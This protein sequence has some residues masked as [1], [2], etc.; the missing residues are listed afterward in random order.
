MNYVF[1]SGKKEQDRYLKVFASAIGAKTVY[2]RHY[3]GIVPARN[4]N[5]PSVKKK[6]VLPGT[7]GIIFCGLLRGNAHI[8]DLALQ[9]NIPYYYVDHAYFEPGY[10]NLNW[11]RIVK[12]GFCQNTI[13]PDVKPNRFAD[14]FNIQLKNYDFK[15]RNNIVVF[16]P[17]NT[18][19]RVFNQTNW[20]AEIVQKI[21]KH[22]DRPIVVRR[23]DGP[24]MDKL[25]VEVRG[26]EK[27]HYVETIEQTLDNAYCVV[28][29]NS[30][31]ALRALEKGIPV[32]C[33]RHCPA[34]PL[35]HSIEEIENLKEKDRLPLFSSL[36]WGQF[37]L[38][39]I[40]NPKTFDHINKIQQWRGPIR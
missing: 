12:N 37:T 18:V 39:E 10:K 3:I 11:M 36:A 33:E 34:Y 30:A 40:S 20:E 5:P 22:T 25:L 19:G 31:L 7:T 28:A 13:I 38:E 29:F 32:I 8:L 4:G 2:T 24:V 1:L 21:R 27:H 16:P 17:S 23:K 35:S 9:N 26:Q 6:K 15:R 14:R